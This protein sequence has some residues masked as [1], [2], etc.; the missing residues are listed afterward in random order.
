MIRR[1]VSS[2]PASRR[3]LIA[4]L[5]ALLAAGTSLAIAACGG[6]ASAAA[7]APAAPADQVPADADGRGQLSGLPQLLVSS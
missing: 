5:A 6:A 7:S 2:W 4:V 1:V 3:G